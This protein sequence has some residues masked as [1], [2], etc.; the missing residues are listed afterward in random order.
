MLEFHFQQLGVL[1]SIVKDEVRNYIVDIFALIQEFWNPSSSIQ[2]TILSL[3][4]AIAISLES[5]FK[6]Y[7]LTLLPDILQTF[8]TDN[9]DRRLPS[10]KVLQVLVV[11]DANL[12]EFL[13]L[14]VPALIGLVER[15]DTPINLKKVAIQT[16]GLLCRK[17]NFS[18]HASRIILPLLRLF[19]NNVT[20]QHGNSLSPSVGVNLG[21][22]SGSI[23][24]AAS[25]QVLDIKSVVMDTICCLIYQM[26]SDFIIFV[27]MINKIL[28]KYHFQHAKYSTLVGKLLK[29][30]QLPQEVSA[31]PTVG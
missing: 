17:I 7:L 15:A 16:I 11:F 19:N 30:E 6:I 31:D 12:E 9:T 25:T 26:T 29:G 27:P 5:E 18:D 4:E 22:S 13:H 2:I 10:H 14:V 20:T 28:M 3:V 8:E 21:S 24:T 23:S 1:V